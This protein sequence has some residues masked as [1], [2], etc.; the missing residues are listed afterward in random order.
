MTSY[1]YKIVP[2]PRRGQKERGLK[3]PEDRFAR[4]LEAALTEHGAK[5]WEYLRAETLPCEERRGLGRSSTVYHSVLVFRRPLPGA[6]ATTVQEVGAPAPGG[7]TASRD[8]RP[9]APSGPG[10]RARQDIPDRPASPA[11]GDGDA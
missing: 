3:T 5:G 8:A 7:L 6:A 1:E 11:G 2:A 10:P 4:T 9:A